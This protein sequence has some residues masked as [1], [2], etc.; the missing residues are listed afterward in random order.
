LFM[1]IPAILPCYI[2]FPSLKCSPHVCSFKTM[3]EPINI[4]SLVLTANFFYLAVSR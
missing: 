4:S 2:K 1:W 3:N